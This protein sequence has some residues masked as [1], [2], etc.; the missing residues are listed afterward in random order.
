MLLTDTI[1]FMITSIKHSSVEFR[2]PKII[3]IINDVSIFLSNLNAD[4]M[5]FHSRYFKNCS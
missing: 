3:S 5:P 2:R 4:K 1:R